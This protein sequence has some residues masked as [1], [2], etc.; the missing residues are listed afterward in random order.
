MD[1]GLVRQYCLTNRSKD[2][3][4]KY[5]RCTKCYSLHRKTKSVELPTV[6]VKH[7]VL[8]T[9]Q[10]VH[11]PDCQPL[12]EAQALATELDRKCRREVRKGHFTPRQ[13]Y[14]KVRLRI[15]FSDGNFHSRRFLQGHEQAVL[16]SEEGGDLESIDG[17]AASY[18]SWS[19]VR[20]QLGRHREGV[21]PPVSD[22]YNLPK[23]Y[24]NSLLGQASG[25]YKRLIFSLIC[26]NIMNGSL[27]VASL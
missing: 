13:V 21:K 4:T 6:K 11:H 2:G 5:Y 26:Y 24:Q 20:R 1:D 10:P 15:H 3:S 8:P 16:L 7:G 27:Q 22:A 12:R 19:L 17:L 25:N 9:E 23:V 14:N 18:P